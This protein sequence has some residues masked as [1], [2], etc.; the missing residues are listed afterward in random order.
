MTTQ[1]YNP[2]RLSCP[3]CGAPVR[4]EIH[5][6]AYHCANCGTKTAP[7]EN[8][9]RIES[10]RRMRQSELRSDGNLQKAAF[11]EC[12]GC[13]ARVVVEEN[14]ASGTCAFCGGTLVRRKYTESDTFPE[15][16]IP[17]DLTEEEAKDSL[18]A[19]IRRKLHGKKKH[20]ALKHLNELEGCYLPYQFVR[21]PITCD[22]DR[23]VSMRKYKAAGYV[24]ELAVNTNKQLTNE[25][26]DA[27]EPFEWE[28]TVP[29]NFGY[30]AGHKVKMQ[31]ISDKEAKQR[32]Y[33]EVEDDF[34]PAAK[35]IMQS[36]SV[37]VT[38]VCS[39]LEQ[40]PVLLPMYFVKSGNLLA[41][42][43]GQTGACALTFHK[44]IDRGRFWWVEPLLTA[45]ILGAIT[46]LLAPS[47]EL[48]FYVFAAAGLIA[49]T[50][51]DN[52]RTSH[53]EMIIYR[54]KREDPKEAVPVFREVVNGKEEN[55]EI[56]FYTPGRIIGIL[57]RAVLF[58]IL[59][60]LIAMFFFWSKNKP[61][62][63][64]DFGYISIWL[65]LSIPFTFIFWIAY[66][67]RDIFDNPLIYLIREDG[68][69]KRVRQKKK[70][71]GVL[72]FLWEA[73]RDR[74]MPFGFF[75]LLIG[76]PALMFFMSIYLMMGG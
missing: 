48:A 36:K 4:Y 27:C 6:G 63:D 11:W 35:K 3:Q 14:E 58:N 72:V 5:S 38:A 41:S 22:I 60:L 56:R 39:D 44:Y 45:L 42:V 21:G 10:W 25:V 52:I 51:F 59:P 69:V 75:L 62:A 1:E 2:I 16:I 24:N 73:I 18:K 49:W 40:L 65:I 12:P 15:M 32:V 23:D 28:D 29:F 71:L 46:Y 8:Y 33:K 19:F 43:N 37:D 17:F 50:A 13:G 54:D 31:D 61:V 67:R 57:F 34:L 70:G 20:D 68:S 55:V 47:L 76:L 9:K 74:D 64:L 26:L 53:E 30:I 7:A 66:M